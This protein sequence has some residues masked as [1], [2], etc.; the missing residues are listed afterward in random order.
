MPSS[1]AI[2]RWTGAQKLNSTLSRLGN[3]LAVAL[4]GFVVLYT[5]KA[6]GGH[7]GTPLARGQSKPELRSASVEAFRIAMLVTAGLAFAGA[8]V[9]AIGIS[10]DEARRRPDEAE[11]PAPAAG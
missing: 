4:L 7:Q 2:S 6:N 11:A 10:N 8:G 1:Y 3:L 5:F 9:A